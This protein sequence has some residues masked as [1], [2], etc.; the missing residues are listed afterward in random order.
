MSKFSTQRLTP[1][2]FNEG[3]PARRLAA[4][5]RAV[6]EPVEARMMM[7]ASL[8]SV[9]TQ[10]IATISAK[11]ETDPTAHSGDSANDSAVWVDT[12]NSSRSTIIGTDKLGAL[13]VYDLTGNQ[14]QTITDAAY[15]NVDV[16]GDLVAAT[17]ITTNTISFFQVDAS[18]RKLVNVT[19]GTNK[20]SIG[21]RVNGLAMYYN[22]ETEITYAFV[23]NKT[24]G[25]EQFELSVVNN[26]TVATSVRTLSLGSGVE[27]MVVDDA[28]DSLYVA[29]EQV[30]IWKYGAQP[31]D[32]DV[33]VQIDGVGSKGHITADVEG[34]AIYKA[35]NGQG[36]LIASS[37][38]SSDYVV[39]DRKSGAYVTRFKIRNNG[40]DI[41]GT[42]NTSGIEVVNFNLGGQ[43]SEGAFI[44]QDGA[45]DAQESNSNFKIVSWGDIA[46]A[47][48]IPLV[49]DSSQN[50]DPEPNPS[51]E[52]PDGTPTG[53]TFGISRVVLY[54]VRTGREIMELKQGSVIDLSQVQGA[55]LNVKALTIGQVG[56]VVF[57]LDG[58][59][60]YRTENVEPYALASDLGTW[61]P[62]VGS[63]QLTVK[64]Y[65]AGVVGGSVGGGKSFTFTVV[66]GDTS[67]DT[68][69]AAPST[70]TAHQLGSDE[71]QLSWASF[72]GLATGFKI[73]RSLNG[74][75]YTQ[76]ATVGGSAR[77]YTDTNVNANTKY[78]YQVAGY[79]SVGT[80]SRSNTASDT[81]G[82]TTV[83]PPPDYPLS[84]EIPTPQNTGPDRS[85]SFKTVGGFVAKSNTVYE[86]LKIN[87]MIDARNTTGVIIRN[88]IINGGR[89]SGG[90]GVAYSVR[91]DG[92][93][94]LVV[95]N[96]EMSYF[97][98]AAIFGSG[99]KAIGNYVHHSGGDGF[100]PTTDAVIQG[101]YVSHLGYA[102]PD[103]HADG[104]QIRDGHDI[105]IVANFFDMPN[106]ITN[107]RANAALF[108][109]GSNEGS[110][111][112][113]YEGNWARGG[114]FT[115]RAYSDN[116]DA[117]S[118]KIV[119]NF[120]WKGY[121]R[122]GLGNNEDGVI[123]SGNKIADTLA[124]ALESIK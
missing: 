66:Q 107:T 117:S 47:Q 63:H 51:S 40:G 19:G 22:Y 75:T 123:W 72:D 111:N 8:S 118:I 101:N 88:C 121:S 26:K 94:K 67:A 39:Y 31:T 83:V 96:C 3:G 4:A 86:N 33:R 84:D 74:S 59:P 70:L 104:V 50:P 105:T 52:T 36:Y 1:G 27:G 108:V 35:S 28:T 14:I 25:V 21:G 109:Q 106:N 78:Y 23:S 122:F 68:A 112:I 114:N 45:N 48:G 102:A 30:G 79:N 124:N 5:T 17:N 13:N 77:A 10:Q 93:N 49:I 15:N 73:Y 85:K 92:A 56:S 32:S 18:T 7:S 12:E 16:R 29:Q 76:V 95:E 90:G 34:L 41:D 37:Q 71:V 98:S 38:G 97:A 64:T 120:F 46:R 87:G 20:L 110:Y 43:L 115:I 61:S 80:S 24:G 44:V 2:S 60:N 82:S 54:D 81:T 100:K 119:N 113:T 116:G 99:F 103:A 89:T 42:S 91:C 65:G 55:Q 6:M 57:G 53:S 9:A 69:P 58:N 62:K 11:Y